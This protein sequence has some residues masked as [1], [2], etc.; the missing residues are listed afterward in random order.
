MI[1]AACAPPVGPELTPVNAP[2][3][4]VS[5]PLDGSNNSRQT[6]CALAAVRASSD[7]SVATWS[8]SVSIAARACCALPAARHAAEGGV[9]AAE[10]SPIGTRSARVTHSRD[11]RE[12]S[13]GEISPTR[14]PSLLCMFYVV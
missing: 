3:V 1:A 10:A 9:Q 5:A 6:L 2:T 14:L 8:I 7:H 12:G 11:G 4:S 13:E